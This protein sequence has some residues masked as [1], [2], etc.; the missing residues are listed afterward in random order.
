MQGETVD[1]DVSVT[2]T[3][4]SSPAYTLTITKNSSMATIKDGKL[5][6]DEDATIGAEIIVTATTTDKDVNGNKLTDT[7]SV[8]VTK[9][10]SPRIQLLL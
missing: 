10:E 8:E 4:L 2:G 1:L 9:A 5:V 7:C 3:D 6:I